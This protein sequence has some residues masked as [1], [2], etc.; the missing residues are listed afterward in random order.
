MN[1]LKIGDTV[2]LKS[3]GPEMTVAGFSDGDIRIMWFKDD[4]MMQACVDAGVLT[5]IDEAPV[6]L[7]ERNV[8]VAYNAQKCP[9]EVPWEKVSAA[10]R[11]RIMSFAAAVLD[12]R[13]LEVGRDPKHRKD[14]TL[15]L[16]PANI[17]AAAH[18]GMAAYVEAGGLDFEG[19]KEAAFA[20]AEAV[21]KHAMEEA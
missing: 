15:R 7:L 18:V 3:G 19:L 5:K 16:C 11:Q 8:R 6:N 21:I 17:H 9:G 10:Q 20:F 14:R 13:L 1:D 4:M 12:Q 2:R